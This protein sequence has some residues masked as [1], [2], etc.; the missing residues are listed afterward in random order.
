[1]GNK[2]CGYSCKH[3]DGDRSHPPD[4]YLPEVHPV[5]IT[6]YVVIAIDLSPGS[7]PGRILYYDKIII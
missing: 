5:F 7:L 2:R 3:N 6:T 4:N 1:M